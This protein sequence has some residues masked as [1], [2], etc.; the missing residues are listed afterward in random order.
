M[1]VGAVPSARFEVV[2]LQYSVD[3]PGRQSSHPADFGDRG[4]RLAAEAHRAD[5]LEIG[6]EHDIERVERRE[7]TTATTIK[8][9]MSSSAMVT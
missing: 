7:H 3:P 4:E 1:H 9:T 2:F 5:A 8:P 6:R